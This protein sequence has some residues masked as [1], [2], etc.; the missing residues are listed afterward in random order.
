MRAMVVDRLGDVPGALHL[1]DADLPEPAE[2]EALIRVQAAGVGPWD[3]AMRRG[4][5]TG[6]VPYIPGGEFAGVI[7]G[8][9]GADA[10]FDDGAP[11][12]G[13]PG[14]SGCFAEYVSCPFEQLAPIPSGL[15]VVEA[16]GA[17]IDGLTAEQGLTDILSVGAGDQILI[18]AAAGGLGHLAVQ[19]ARALG[20]AVVA[21][22]SPRNH[23][24]VHKLGAAMV[25]D[26]NQPDWPDQV[27]EMTD[28]GPVKVLACAR[29][30]LE[31]AARAARE[32]AT[33]ATPVH[34]ELP[35]P[36]H[37]RWRPYDG[38]ASG[39]R[40]IR[41][42]PWFDEGTLAVHVEAKYF[43]ADAQ[44]ALTKAEHGHSRGRIVLI[45][46]E[47]LAAELEV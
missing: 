29:Q 36:E 17:P 21:T 3:V 15:S 20:A 47:D 14:L 22:A 26:H 33:I 4:A 13:Y 45:V 18:T 30:T 16:A 24:F 35:S 44:E 23:D 11:V 1:A 27:R 12:Y 8:D 31:G 39:S 42:A 9:T 10:A 7:V 25:V 2:G 41:M 32:G 38:Q 37:V 40:L 43:L 34:A 6:P 28:G 19:I 46:D 5:W